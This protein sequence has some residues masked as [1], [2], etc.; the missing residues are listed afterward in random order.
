VKSLTLLF[1]LAIGLA[2]AFGQL[3]SLESKIP[4]LPELP[5]SLKAPWEKIDSIRNKFNAEAG[6]LKGKYDQALGS[7]EQQTIEINQ[8]LDSLRQLSLPTGKLTRKLDS[9]NQLRQKTIADFNTKVNGLKSKT[10]GQ[11]DKIEMT[12]GM[13]GPVAEFTGKIN[14]FN[15]TD[16]GFVKIPPVEIPGFSLPKLEGLDL[17]GGLPDLANIPKIETPLGDISQV[18]DQIQGVSEDVKNIAQGNLDDVKAIP[19]A[20]EQQAANIDGVKHLQEQ[21]AIVDGYK[22]QL[23]TLGDQDAMKKQLVEQAKKEAI[24]HFAGKEE[25]LKAAMDKVSKYKQKYSSVSSLKDLPKRPPNAMKGKPFVERLVPGIYFQFQQKNAYLLDVNPY[26]GYKISGRFFSGLGWNQRFAYDRKQSSFV[27]DYRIYGPRSFVDFKLG[28]GFIA[29]LEG[30]AMNTFVPSSTKTVPEI[31]S[32]E[33]VWSIQMGMK[34]QYKIYKNLHGTVLL[35]YNFINQYFKTPYVDRLNSRIGF[36][37]M[38]RKKRKVP[39]A[40]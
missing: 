20:I 39:E 38:L 2:P 28:K 7:I 29:H 11:L 40:R 4:K 23:E 15:L 25:Q 16:N 34:K 21:S 6:E 37:Y 17:P 18:T 9:L 33:W 3:D 8:K 27:P 1:L 10:I 13:Q 24:N 19:D 5:D 22:E 12:P 35:Q 36:E 32:R 31:G 26:L 30:E 14:G